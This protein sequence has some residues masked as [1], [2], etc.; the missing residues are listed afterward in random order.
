MLGFGK[1]GRSFNIFA[2]SILLIALMVP[3]SVAVNVLTGAGSQTSEALLTED[4]TVLSVTFSGGYTISVHVKNSGTL[5]FAV[6]GLWVNNV[7]QAFTTN[8]SGTVPPNGSMEISVSYAYVNGTSY[9]IKIVSD[10]AN[11]YFASATAL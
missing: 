6:A 10:R 3:V 7:K 4:L 9:H 1:N 11:E 2:A 8:S 5:D